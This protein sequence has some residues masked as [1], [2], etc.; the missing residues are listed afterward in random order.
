MSWPPSTLSLVAP[1]AH[2]L[3]LRHDYSTSG[4]QSSEGYFW[5]IRSCP[6]CDIPLGKF[7]L[8]SVENLRRCVILMEGIS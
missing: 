6:K 2:A 3:S 1:Y 7:T 4:A 5:S 8:F